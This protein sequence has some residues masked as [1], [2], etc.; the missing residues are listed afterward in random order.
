MVVR[1][2]NLRCSYLQLLEAVD[3]QSN[4]EI[5][6]TDHLKTPFPVVSSFKRPLNELRFLKWFIDFEEM[7]YI[8]S[9][10]YPSIQ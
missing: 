1:T 5:N 10:S 8:L 3:N 9:L 6:K 7:F 2:T 4:E